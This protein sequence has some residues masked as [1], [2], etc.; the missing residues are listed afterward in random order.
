VNPAASVAA[1]PAEA[2]QV[3]WVTLG[4]ALL[5]IVVAAAALLLISRELQT[6]RTSYSDV[7]HTRATLDQLR[8]V[9]SSL[10]DAEPGA[11]GFVLTG[12]EEFLSPYCTAERSLAG[13]LTALL[14]LAPERI[15]RACAAGAP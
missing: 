7:L 13:Q 9:F 6:G 3:L 14:E 5:L 2:G 4:A 10:Q 11:Q 15:G 1:P 12:N 8:I